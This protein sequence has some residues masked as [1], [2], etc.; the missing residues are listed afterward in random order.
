MRTSTQDTIAPNMSISEFAVSPPAKEPSFTQA[1]TQARDPD[2]PMVFS[3]GRVAN[4]TPSNLA[5]SPNETLELIRHYRYEV[6]PWVS[7][8]PSTDSPRASSDVCNKL[9]ICDLGQLFGIQGLQIAMA[10][11]MVWYSV[12]ALS[13]ASMNLL[14][15]L[16]SSVITDKTPGSPATP[17]T[18]LDITTLAFHRAMNES[19]NCILNFQATWSS[20]RVCDREF[21]DCLGPQTVG[22]DLNAAIYWLFVRLGK[23]SPSMSITRRIKF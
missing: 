21:L 10:S 20:Q 19:R 1:M 12:L 23:L 11:Q 2:F 9:D 6:A 5:I 14:R 7:V 16:S 22:H 15:P 13:E 8:L 18:Q 17:E 4:A 3:P